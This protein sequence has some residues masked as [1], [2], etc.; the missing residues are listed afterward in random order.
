MYNPA[1][2]PDLAMKKI[3]ILALFITL[4]S[5]FTFPGERP[6]TTR[7]TKAVHK[8]LD[9]GYTFWGNRNVTPCP[10]KNLKVSVATDLDLND[11]VIV[12]ARADDRDCSMYLDS[13]LFK[14]KDKWAKREMC[15]HVVHEIGH[16][17]G[18]DH[19]HGGIMSLGLVEANY[20]WA[21][22]KQ[23]KSR[24]RR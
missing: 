21:C 14:Y 17:G 1:P 11:D 2:V 22:I 8:S 3:I 9:I 10:R 4:T 19:S 13:S 20:P 16:L 24:R 5:G 7:E 15:S 12:M 6:L 23:Y 18:L